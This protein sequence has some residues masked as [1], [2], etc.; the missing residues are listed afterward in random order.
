[1]TTETRR[2]SIGG[3]AVAVVRKDIKNLHV[4]VYPPDGRVRVAVPL[5][6]SDNAVRSAIASRLGWIKRQRRSFENQLRES[7]R[8][9]VSGE[10]LYFLGQRYRVRLVV[11]EA[12]RYVA[13]RG[14]TME[15]HARPGD[16]AARRRELI[17]NWY[18]EQLRALIPPLL[19]KWQRRVGARADAF[20]IKRMKTKW[21]SCSAA[22]RRIWLNLELAK[23][24]AACLEYVIVH[25]LVHLRFLHHDENFSALM[26][27]LLP[28]WPHA[29]RLLNAAPLVHSEWRY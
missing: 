25:E 14:R 23:K 8:E 6:V 17:H 24:P 28:R 15:V 21:G 20:G 1:M 13:L 5:A 4:G 7:E 3:I 18:R 19:R 10:T 27:R 29:R 11:E 16:D 12:P 2:F 9:V 26:Y 22:R